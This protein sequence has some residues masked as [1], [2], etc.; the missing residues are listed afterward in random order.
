MAA[1]IPTGG[2]EMIDGTNF[3]GRLLVWLASV[4]A[5]LATAPV[6]VSFAAVEN[7]DSLV[8]WAETAGG[9][10]SVATFSKSAGLPSIASAKS[11]IKTWLSG[12]DARL[13]SSVFSYPA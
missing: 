5:V 10:R 4:Q 13:D 6:G 12:L 11:T 7:G 3:R 1:D 8:L 2:V 9:R